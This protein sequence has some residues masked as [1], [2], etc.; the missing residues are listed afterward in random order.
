MNMLQSLYGCCT[1]NDHLLLDFSDRLAGIEAF[2]A[3]ARAVHDCVATV[4]LEIVV[5]RLQSLFGSLVARIDDPA[6][7]LHQNSGAEVLVA[8]PPVPARAL[9]SEGE[10]DEQGMRRT[11]GMKWS[12]KHREYIRKDHPTWLGSPW[13]ESSLSPP[14]CWSVA[15]VGCFCTERRSC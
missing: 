6:I 9:E 8:I 15:K 7:S 10:H 3:S 2:G 11:K 13:F 14:G 4:Q 12:S 1:S 5:E